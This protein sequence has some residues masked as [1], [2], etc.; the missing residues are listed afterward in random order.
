MPCISCRVIQ[1][2][3]LFSA[4]T[5]P[6]QC[7]WRFVWIFVFLYIF[8]GNEGLN[9]L[10]TAMSFKVWI[11]L[12]QLS[13]LSGI[14]NSRWTKL[15]YTAWPYGQWDIA[16]IIC[17]VIVDFIIIL[18]SKA[19]SCISMATYRKLMDMF[20]QPSR[21]DCK[22]LCILFKYLLNRL[23]CLS[24]PLYPIRVLSTYLKY[25]EIMSL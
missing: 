2:R 16:Q 15:L 25:K 4:D 8:I 13:W 19:L 6:R 20:I 7:C 9:P 12:L 11:T 3:S 10:E 17:S 1:W 18:K 14:K 24:C 23:T 5:V 22:F 21:V